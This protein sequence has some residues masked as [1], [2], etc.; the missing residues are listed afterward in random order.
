MCK[1]LRKIEKD[2]WIMVFCLA[3]IFA[4]TVINKLNLLSSWLVYSLLGFFF[5]IMIIFLMISIKK[6]KAQ[7]KQ[8]K[9]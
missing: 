3:A 5:I 1:S 8:G 4:L 6:Q 7:E 2:L 9:N